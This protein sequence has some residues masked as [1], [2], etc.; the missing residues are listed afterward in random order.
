MK[1]ELVKIADLI[2]AEKNTRTH[3]QKQISELVRSFQKFG[4]IRPVVID[5]NNVIWCGNGF[6]MAAKEAG[7]SEVAC[8]RKIGL[9]EDDKRK[10]MLADN[11]I[12]ML[13]GANT[14]VMD[15]FLSSM[16]DFDVPGFDPATLEQLYGEAERAA[17]TM[18][19]YG[20]F[21]AG[22]TSAMAEVGAQRESV[23]EQRVVTPQESKPAAEDESLP[24][25]IRATNGAVNIPKDEGT[26][27]FIICPR[28]GEKIWL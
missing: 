22:T 19:G 18:M 26:R 11:Q 9:T 3:N 7:A 23:S 24:P 14:A 5:E 10:L 8:L 2:P 13:G 28:C 4:Q 20:T 17:E 16:V 1:I 12:F 15:E 25:T 21:D 6:F 27:P